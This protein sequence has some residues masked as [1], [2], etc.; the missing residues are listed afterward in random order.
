MAILEILIG[1]ACLYAGGELLVR[2]STSLAKNLGVSTLII[3]LTVVAF[4][5]SAPE[6]AVNIT[7]ALRG[8]S[9]ISF[10]NI[11][12]SNIANLG[13][14]LGLAAFVRPLDILRS[15][16]V[17]DIPLM[18]AATVAVV[19]LSIRSLLGGQGTLGR[20]DG[21]LL[22][23][24]FGVFLALTLRRAMSERRG[25]AVARRASREASDREPS[26]MPLALLLTLLGL[27]GVL[28]GGRWT[29]V[30]ATA[31]ARSLGVGEEI[32]G[33]S[34]VAV[35]TSLPELAASLTA[36]RRGQSDLA[37]GNVVGSNLFNLLL[38]LGPTALI[39]PLPV[40]IGGQRDLY[41][42]LFFSC[43]LLPMGLAGDR[44]INRVEGGLFL[45]CYCAYLAWRTL[46]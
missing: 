17:R 41:A 18:L 29:V 46:G 11:V 5:T 20:V 43:L 22:L 44:K 16:A 23:A 39:R 8:Q 21:V 6:L 10:G 2:G 19:L 14:I 38:V 25:S 42:L 26:S 35:G 36:A 31:I 45:L 24:G 34:I 40:P 30:G 15:M 7:A 12:G 27:V 1:L 33:L 13:L 9:G 28:L 3:G 32:I 37:V 4:G